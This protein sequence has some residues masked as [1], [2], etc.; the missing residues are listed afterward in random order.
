MT[1]LSKIFLPVVKNNLRHLLTTLKLVVR[2]VLTELVRRAVIIDPTAGEVT[3]QGEHR[4]V[5]GVVLRHPGQDQGDVERFASE[6][7]VEM[8]Q[9]F[10]GEERKDW[11]ELP[12]DGVGEEGVILDETDDLLGPAY[13]TEE[14]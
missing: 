14:K 8:I 10:V 7:Q 11:L 5:V 1:D 9:V 13:K 12:P 4:A 2:H 6:G 3:L